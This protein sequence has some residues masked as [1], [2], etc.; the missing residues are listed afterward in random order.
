M[1]SN[2]QHPE[3]QKD[4]S[5]AEMNIDSPK[6]MLPAEGKNEELKSLTPDEDSDTNP[7]QVDDKASFGDTNREEQTGKFDGEVGI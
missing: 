1:E 4:R 5:D 2:S 6:N 3:K 7:D